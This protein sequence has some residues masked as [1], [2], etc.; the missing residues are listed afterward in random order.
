MKNYNKFFSLFA[1]AAILI[2]GASCEEN[3]LVPGG[4]IVEPGLEIMVTDEAEEPAPVSGADVTV[5][6]TVND[7]LNNTN[8]VATGTTD[9]SGM[10]A[11][12]KSDL[13]GEPSSFIVSVAS[14][15]LRNWNNSTTVPLMTM[16]SGVTQFSTAVGSLPPGFLF[17]SSNTFVFDS[18][19]Y[20]GGADA[21]PACESGDEFK[22]QRN[23]EVWRY[24]GANACAAPTDFQLPLYDVSGE[25]NATWSLN[26]DGSEITT[27]DYDPT[28][29]AVADAALTIDEAAGT[30]VINYGGGYIANFSV[31]N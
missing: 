4:A 8:P 10:I 3:Q 19:L 9:A 7:F 25:P 20:P 29:E 12:S 1:M 28:W 21:L 30:V 23:G 6:S 26:A 13:G 5:Y 2:A 17:L 14:G 31:K 22:F 27:R 16:T 18:Y 24:D 15:D 11:F